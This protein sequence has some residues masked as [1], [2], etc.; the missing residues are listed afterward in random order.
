MFTESLVEIVKFISDALLKNYINQISS[1]KNNKK[2]NHSNTQIRNPYSYST[3]TVHKEKLDKNIK[4]L[5]TLTFLMFVVI[6]FFQ[7]WQNNN[8]FSQQIKFKH[9]TVENGI[10]NNIVNTLIQDKSGFMWFGTNDGLNRY[11]GYDFKIFRHNPEDSNSISDNSIHSLFEDK[12]GGIWIGTKSGVLNKYNPRT[13]KF[14]KIKLQSNINVYN[15][16]ESI[17]EDNLGNLWLG[18]HLEGLYKI[19]VKNSKIDHWTA[20]SNKPKSLSNNYILSI[21]EDNNGNIVIGTYN[22]LNIFNPAEPQNGF[23]KFYHESN[24]PNSLNDNLIWALSKSSIATNIIWIGNS[25]GVTEYNSAYSTFRR[26]KLDNTTN[27]QFGESCG[28]TIDEINAG[29]KIMWVLSYGGLLRVNLA[30]GISRRFIHDE[31]NSQSLSNNHINKILKD[32]TGVIWAATENGISYF[33]PK[34]TSF[35]FY[36]FDYKIDSQLKG[37]DITALSKLSKDKIWVGTN[38]GLFLLSNLESNPKL[39]R[40]SK[41]DGL[42]IWSLLSPNSNELWIGTY[43]KG[44]KQFNYINGKITDWDINKTNVGGQSIY[45]NKTLLED[46]EQ[47]I[48]IGY[49]GAGLAKLN[50]KTGSYKVWLKEPENPKSL[51][52]NSV[53]TI[54]EDRFGRIW[55]GTYGGGLNLFEDKDGGLFHHWL[56]QESN[57]YKLSS[58]NIFSIH[59]AKNIKDGDDSEI[60]LWIGTDNGLNKFIVK[61]KKGDAD[62]FDISVKSEIYDIEDGLFDNTI[63][64]ISED[65]KGNLWLGTNSGISF[66]DVRKKA[67]INY[68]KE[69][70][71]NGILMNPESAL[72]LDNGLILI[73]GNEGFNIFDP[74]KMK[75]SSYKPNLVITD[76][77]IF[78]KPIKIGKNFQFKESIQTTKEI[79]LSYNQEV[80]SFEFAA[81]D[82]NSSKTIQYSYIMEGFDKDWIKSGTRRFASYTNLDPGEYT[83]KIKSTNA[84]GIWNDRSKSIL[85]IITPPFW[86][87]WWAYITYCLVFIICFYLISKYRSNKRK[88][89]EEERLNAVIEREKLTQAE[90]RVEAAEYKTRVIETEKEIE[91]QQIRNRISA[92]LHDEIGSNLSSII[93]LSS[94]VDKKQNFDDELRKYITEIHGAAK[95]SAEAIRDIVWFI[96][97]ASDQ[98]ANLVSKMVQTSNTMLSSIEHELIKSNF[99]VTEKLPPNVKRNVF[100][101]YKEILNNIIKH[102]RADFVSI[103]IKQ[104]NNIFEF[105]VTDNGV[106]IT[107]DE[108]NDG[109]GLKNLKFRADQI[110]ANLQ[111]SSKEMKGTTITLIYSMA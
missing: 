33:T 10:S 98:I 80:F 105:S 100:L 84:D 9:L 2:T 73:G 95:I 86:K 17:Y 42:N 7:C 58:N 18:T 107:L 92:D 106:G 60:I 101:I 79:K 68:T 23:K 20:N 46:S 85:I 103:N 67:F 19:N 25:K 75:L 54:K 77:K 91:K 93:L 70:G 66:F 94:L 29:E 36:S 61:N 65:N 30:T 57:K 49:W 88:K 1:P 59:E 82:Y 22:G 111:I 76:F 97:P 3:I 109:N 96:N 14:I 48:W 15:G 24:N 52:F 35:N 83:F 6:L 74:S 90:L 55:L 41:F 26:I 78:N 110:N 38:E 13:E 12:K 45:F 104:E 11:D 37:K 108:N 21:L 87:T 43:G 44:L 102:S 40:I 34:S 5:H 81:L 31:T 4:C 28:Y 64:S 99:D 71:I 89:K 39:E 51:S 72:N 8:L 32:R 63:N 47:N 62:L 50:P 69:D 53:W 27:L 16:I 56:K